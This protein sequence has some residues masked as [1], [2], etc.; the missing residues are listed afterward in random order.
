MGGSRPGFGAARHVRTVMVALFA[1]PLTNICVG[2][3]DALKV[4]I[5]RHGEKPEAGD[6]LSCQGEN[7]ALALSAV[8]S[9]K[10]ERPDYTYVPA[11]ALGKASKHARMFQ[12]VTPFAIRQ[13]LTL[14]TKYDEADVDGVAKDVLRRTGLALLVWEHSQIPP[15]AKALGVRHP[16]SWN[17]DDFDSIWVITRESGQTSMSVDAQEIHPSPQ[18]TF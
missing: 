6:N 7:R 3:S 16:P 8:L 13:N 1:V 4:V 5:I 12:T 11:M 17:D 9:A 14:N 10:F 15:L 18:C 2:A